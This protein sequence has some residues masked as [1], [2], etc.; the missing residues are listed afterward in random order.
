MLFFSIFQNSF[1]SSGRL[2][3]VKQVQT[4]QIIEFITD[5]FDRNVGMNVKLTAITHCKT[6][7]FISMV[8]HEEIPCVTFLGHNWNG[9]VTYRKYFHSILS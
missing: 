2:G 9:G 1:P 6:H 7:I 5:G 8:K 3:G 4:N